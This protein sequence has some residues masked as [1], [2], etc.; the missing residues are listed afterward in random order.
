M[1]IVTTVTYKRVIT[2][3]CQLQICYL[4]CIIVV[5]HSNTVHWALF[6]MF[7]NPRCVVLW[8]KYFSLVDGVGQWFVRWLGERA[9]RALSVQSQSSH[10]RIPASGL[11]SE[12]PA[13]HTPMVTPF[14]S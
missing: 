4:W 6:V 9:Y 8:G 1:A 2:C 3:S 11:G 7:R 13:F 12:I 14:S 10:A 5:T